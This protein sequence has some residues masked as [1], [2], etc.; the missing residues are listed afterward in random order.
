[1]ISPSKRGNTSSVRCN[2]TLVALAS[3]RLQTITHSPTALWPPGEARQAAE[4][5]KQEVHM[6]E[7]PAMEPIKKDIGSE[8]DAL[9]AANL[10][11]DAP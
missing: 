6:D 9:L 2:S 8:I 7:L 3:R 11:D 1:M 4:V 5:K 10:A